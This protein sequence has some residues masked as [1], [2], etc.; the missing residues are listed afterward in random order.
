MDD[1][2]LKWQQFIAFLL[3]V[4]CES[5]SLNALLREQWAVGGFQWNCATKVLLACS[6]ACGTE[7]GSIAFNCRHRWHAW[8]PKSKQLTVVGM[9]G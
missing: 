6:K 9:E 2:K 7:L 4:G 8:P 3:S 5:R 1:N